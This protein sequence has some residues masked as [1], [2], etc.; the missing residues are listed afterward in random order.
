MNIVDHSGS[1]WVTAF[2]EV[3]ELVLGKCALDIG[4]MVDLEVCHRFK[5]YF[6]YFLFRKKMN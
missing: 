5:I 3:A 1:Q 4:R 6:C 2:Q